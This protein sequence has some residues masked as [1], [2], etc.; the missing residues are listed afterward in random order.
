MPHGDTG[1]ARFNIQGYI[2]P[3]VYDGI[4]IL[5]GDKAAAH[6]KAAFASAEDARRRLRGDPQ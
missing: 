3:H 5:T 2:S 4:R 6:R 1:R